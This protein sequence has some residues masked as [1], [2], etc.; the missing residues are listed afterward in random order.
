MLDDVWQSKRGLL[1]LLLL[2][3]CVLVAVFQYDSTTPVRLP[4][5]TAAARFEPT[6]VPKAGVTTAVPLASEECDVTDPIPRHRAM[7][8]AF[9]AVLLE[10]T[11]KGAAELHAINS[12]PPPIPSHMD[13][14]KKFRVWPNAKKRKPFGILCVTFTFAGKKP[15]AAHA[16]KYWGKRC[17]R[18]VLITNDAGVEGIA[19]ED[20]LLVNQTGGE[21]WL[22]AWQKTR[23]AIRTL[24]EAPWIDEYE[25]AFFGGD[26]VMLVV[27]NLRK[28]MDAP[29]MRYAHEAGA[30]LHFGH[31]S[32]IPKQSRFIAGAG[33]AMNTAAL[34]LMAARLQSPMCNP[35]LRA[36]A[37]DVYLSQCLQ[38][39][40]VV[41][42]DTR[43]IY[44]EDRFTVFNPTHHVE[45]VRKWDWVDW[46]IKYRDRQVPQGLDMMSR[47]FINMHYIS[48]PDMTKYGKVIWPADFK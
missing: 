22:N 30:P 38:L 37:E 28:M 21:A 5:T 41:P 3:Q 7:C 42:H 40:G 4:R 15:A 32:S 2:Q 8:A 25:F 19:R 46:W 29:E 45:I 26:D 43:D 39:V 44:G 27:E 48:I 17:D 10:A 18:H 11:T 12:A 14:V 6:A 47:D 33:Y 35:S 34:H 9:D 13:F 16:R 20:A 1:V 24:H 31:L 36:S 23:A